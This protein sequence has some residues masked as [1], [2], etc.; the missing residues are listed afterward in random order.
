MTKNEC[1]KVCDEMDALIKIL[2]PMVSSTH[3]QSRSIAF[4]TPKG[5]G[6]C[7]D[8]VANEPEVI[9]FQQLLDSIRTRTA[10]FRYHYLP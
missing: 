5:A 4:T 10:A 8:F 2:A 7:S 9:H 3:V 6:G 1:E